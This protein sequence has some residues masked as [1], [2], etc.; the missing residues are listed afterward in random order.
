MQ[1]GGGLHP[2]CPTLQKIVMGLA[3][4][5]RRHIRNLLPQL[6]FNPLQVGIDIFR[7]R[8]RAQDFGSGF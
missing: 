7:H 8:L 3:D 6:L 2:P 4:T 1:R 5:I